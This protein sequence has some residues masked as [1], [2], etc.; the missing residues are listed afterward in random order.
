M[1]GR[2]RTT[3]EAVTAPSVPAGPTSNRCRTV[4]AD[5]TVPYVCGDALSQRRDEGSFFGIAIPVG[6]SRVG[7]L[8]F[9]EET[10]G[11]V[12]AWHESNQ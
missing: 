8:Y 2:E 4:T 10:T 3:A 9:G 5:L 7:L 11:Y 6:V 1:K 12:S